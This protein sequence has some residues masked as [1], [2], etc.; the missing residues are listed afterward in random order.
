ML[1]CPNSM[2]CIDLS[3][4]DVFTYDYTASISKKIRPAF[5]SQFRVPDPGNIAMFP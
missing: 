2:T 1:I 4:S 3:C 5:S